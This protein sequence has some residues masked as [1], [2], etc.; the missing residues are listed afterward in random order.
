MTPYAEQDYHGQEA[1][2]IRVLPADDQAKLLEA[3]YQEAQERVT[4]GERLVREWTPVADSCRAGLDIL[5]KA[6]ERKPP[7]TALERG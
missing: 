7:A 4:E 6:Q 3:R 1:A 5:S 2:P